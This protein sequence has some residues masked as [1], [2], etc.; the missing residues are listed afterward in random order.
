MPGSRLTELRFFHVIAF[1]GPARLISSSSHQTQAR[2]GLPWFIASAI[3]Q[4]GSP[5]V[6]PG[7]KSL[8]TPK[9]PGSCNQ[10]L[11]FKVQRTQHQIYSTSWL[12]SISY[13]LQNLFSI[14]IWYCT[15]ARNDFSLQDIYT[16]TQAFAILMKIISV[17]SFVRLLLELV[18]DRGVRPTT[19]NAKIN[20][21]SSDFV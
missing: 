18:R 13:G 7:R 14:D 20:N 16:I 8:G 11:N 19:F 3:N 17:Q 9:Q 15:I 4:A 21:Q 1:A 10:A 12:S 6:I 2:S 5:H